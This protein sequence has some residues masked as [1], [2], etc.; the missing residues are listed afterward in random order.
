MVRALGKELPGQDVIDAPW[1]AK[2]LGEPCRERC[3]RIAR[4]MLSDSALRGRYL[5]SSGALP[6]AWSAARTRGAARCRP[7]QRRGTGKGRRQLGDH[8][9]PGGAVAGKAPDPKKPTSL[10]PR[11][12][13]IWHT[14]GEDTSSL[15]AISPVP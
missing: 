10:S 5:T 11:E 4:T 6:F 3:G 13:L 12:W 9:L 7:A 2:A 1:E 15:S 8:Y 14:R